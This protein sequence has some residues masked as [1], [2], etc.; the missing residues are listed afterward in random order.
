MRVWLFLFCISLSVVSIAQEEYLHI[1]DS[2]VGSVEGSKDDTVKI[3][4]YNYLS[5]YLRNHNHDLAADYANKAIT[6]ANEG[7]S[8]LFLTASY[9]ELAYC[10]QAIG[11]YQAAQDLYKKSL[12]YIKK[13]TMKP[14]LPIR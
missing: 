5:A 3:N 11:D 1:V 7:D 10:K 6:L 8:Y 12:K 14:V 2:V 9:D 13:K 4:A